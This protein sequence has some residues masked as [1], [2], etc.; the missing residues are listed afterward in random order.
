MAIIPMP[1]SNLWVLVYHLINS[2]NIKIISHALLHF[3]IPP[4]RSFYHQIDKKAF[5]RSHKILSISHTNTILQENTQN[6]RILTMQPLINLNL[7]QQKKIH[8]L[9][10]FYIYYI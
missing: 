10:Q 1:G 9:L 7:L 5:T 4:I 8:S 3:F 6:L 2:K